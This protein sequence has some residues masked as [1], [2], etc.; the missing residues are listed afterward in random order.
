MHTGCSV[1]TVSGGA[2]RRRG[3]SHPRGRASD[4]VVFHFCGNGQHPAPS[5]CFMGRGLRSSYASRPGCSEHLAT[6]GCIRPEVDRHRLRGGGG[7]SRPRA[8]RGA[9]AASCGGSR[10]PAQRRQARELC[11]LPPV[12]DS[13]HARDGQR[14]DRPIGGRGSGPPPDIT[15]GEPL[16]RGT[17]RGGRRGGRRTGRADQAAS[18][19][20]RGRS[21]H[22]DVAAGWSHRPPGPRVPGDAPHDQGDARGRPAPKVGG[23]RRR[24]SVRPGQVSDIAGQGHGR[25]DAAPLSHPRAAAEDRGRVPHRQQ[26]RAQRAPQGSP[27]HTPTSR[28]GFRGATSRGS[29]GASS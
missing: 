6:H 21:A 8:G 15:T 9:S 25:D 13:E 18:A 3:R 23:D 10:Q 17:R 26:A 20:Q 19:S 28:T 29:R 2:P 24:R 7:R 22:E 16:R 12:G 11:S 14:S 4:S 1:L 27:G 5:A